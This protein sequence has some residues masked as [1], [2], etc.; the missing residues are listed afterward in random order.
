MFSKE[1]ESEALTRASGTG[2]L[3]L[4]SCGATHQLLTRAQQNLETAD[5]DNR[6]SRVGAADGGFLW[7]AA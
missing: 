3:R 7:A 6:A 4:A 1:V 2:F 5:K